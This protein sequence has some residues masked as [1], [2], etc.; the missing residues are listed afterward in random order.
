MLFAQ[1]ITL[2]WQK[3]L[4]YPAY[5][6]Q[7]RAERFRLLPQECP[8]ENAVLLH[9]VQLRQTADG[10]SCVRERAEGYDGLAFSADR[11]RQSPFP[12]RLQVTAA[13]GAYRI[14]YCGK[15]CD[16][17]FREKMLLLPGEY[18]R[19]IYNE[20]GAYDYSGIWYYDLTVCNFVNA[21]YSD[22]RPK[23]FFRKEP[24]HLFEDLRYLRYC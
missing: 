22:Y 9:T 1:I 18:G 17:L 15:E 14:A 12:V 11:M 7:R 20:R 5:A 3:E 4:R 13:D 19:V 24:D 2:R 21:P 23:L 6:A 16:G 8:A 10:I